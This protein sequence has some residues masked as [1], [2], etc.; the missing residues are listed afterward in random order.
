MPGIDLQYRG[1]NLRKSLKSF[2]IFANPTWTGKIIIGDSGRPFHADLLEHCPSLSYGPLSPCWTMR[3]EPWLK[4]SRI[5]AIMNTPDPSPA[6][7]C[8]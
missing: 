2:K 3:P 1:M 5:T 8:A 6:P 4:L 7:V